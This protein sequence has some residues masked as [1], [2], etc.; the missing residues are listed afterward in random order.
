MIQKYFFTSLLRTNLVGF[1]CILSDSDSHPFAAKAGFD[2]IVLVFLSVLI[3]N[4][5]F[6]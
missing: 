1:S 2:Q 3:I 5:S 4:S 6:E